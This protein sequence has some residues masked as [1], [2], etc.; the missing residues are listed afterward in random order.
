MSLPGGLTAAVADRPGTSYYVPGVRMAKLGPTVQAS[1]EA[2]TLMPESVLGDLVRAEVTRVNT[3]ASQYSLT[4]NNWFLATAEDRK[5]KHD[6]FG[7]SDPRE[8]LEATTR[9]PFWPRFKYND[10]AVLR[11]GQRLR[12]DLRYVPEPTGKPRTA[13]EDEASWTPMVSGPITDIRFAFATGQG[14]Q[15]TVSGE[16]DLSRL[17]DKDEKRVHL[18]RRSEVSIVKQ[19]LAKVNYPLAFASPL[20]EYPPFAT[21]D[22]QGIQ[23]A[24]ADNQCPLDLIQKLAERLDFE[25]FLEFKEFDKPSG[26]LEFHF[27]P[28]RGRAKYNE[29]LRPIFRLDRERNLLD[30]NPTIKVADQNLTAL[31]KGRHRDPLLAKEVAGKASHEIL[32]D[33]LQT[34][35]KL[36]GPL[37]SG[38]ELR[39]KFFGDRPNSLTV[40]NQS[41]LDEVRADWAAK[42]ALRKKARE[43]F[44]IEATTIGVPRIRPGN[45]VEIRGMRAPFDGFFYVTKTVHTFGTDGYRTKIT[46]SRPGMAYPPY[47]S[48]KGNG[49]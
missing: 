1:G 25:V 9:V 5:E 21:D 3:G 22:G 16:D 24:L 45:H 23:E 13:G 10:F 7:A 35:A 11:F 29:K 47:V 49:S 38:P 20:V 14:A 37:L 30:Y 17:K 39:Q 46:A 31:V 41:N 44:T 27:E 18:D 6:T 19:L 36:D 40:P 12:I 4:F 2:G 48:P 15:L 8:A 42:A 43:L 33:E 26:P 32:I 28:Y 34:D